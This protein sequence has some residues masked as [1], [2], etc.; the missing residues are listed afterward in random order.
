MEQLDP[1]RLDEAVDSPSAKGL[2][3]ERA[4]IDESQGKA[5]DCSWA[6]RRRQRRSATAS[7]RVAA[8]GRCCVYHTD[9][10]FTSPVAVEQTWEPIR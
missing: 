9:E 10:A 7:G 2:N 5:D 3:R 6:R 1:A 4:F 8:F